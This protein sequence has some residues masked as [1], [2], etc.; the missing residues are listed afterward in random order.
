MGEN[1]YESIAQQFPEEITG[2]SVGVEN[3]PSQGLFVTAVLVL[4]RTMTT[5][6]QSLSCFTVFGETRKQNL[7]I[8]IAVKYTQHIHI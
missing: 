8:R 6:S 5:S 2:E 3:A 7:L 1:E 4:H